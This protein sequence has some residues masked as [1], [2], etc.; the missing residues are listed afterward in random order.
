M[1]PTDPNANNNFATKKDIDGYFEKLNI[2]TSGVLIVLGLGFV[3]LLIAVLSPII[4]AWR[5]RTA[6]YQDL[7]NQV[8]EQNSK[9]DSLTQI[10][11]KILLKK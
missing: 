3:T 1:N 11:S 10:D 5:F 4:D 7:I 2:L 6:T 9:I 8:Q